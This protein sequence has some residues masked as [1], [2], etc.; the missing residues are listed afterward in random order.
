M[1]KA[2]I[3][4]LVVG[5]V[6]GLASCSQELT[7]LMG[8]MSTNI[9]GIEADTRDAAAATESVNN[10]TTISTNE[11]TGEVE[12]TINLEAAASIT[13][14]ISTIKKSSAKSEALKTQLSETVA[15]NE[16]EAVA[17][18]AAITA[19]ATEVATSLAPK[20][21]ENSLVAEL[22]SV[23]ENVSNSISDNPTKAELATVAI[24]S[25]IATTVN[26]VASAETITEEQ[27]DAYLEQG[28]AAYDTLVVVSDVAKLDV[29]GNIDVASLLR[30]YTRGVSR[31]EDDIPDDVKDKIVAVAQ[32]TFSKLLTML[33]TDKK[34]DVKK[35]NSFI[36]QATAI[37]ASI[38]LSA[39]KFTAENIDSILL[40]KGIDLGLTIDDLCL[41]LVCSLFVEVDKFG[42]LPTYQYGTTNEINYSTYK[43]KTSEL[44]TDELISANHWQNFF[45]EYLT[46]NYDSFSD[47]ANL[48][49][50]DLASYDSN[51]FKL[52]GLALDMNIDGELASWGQIGA[53]DA[54]AKIRDEIANDLGDVLKDI[55]KGDV[56]SLISNDVLAILKASAVLLVDC[57]YTGL[58]KLGGGDGSF[59]GLIERIK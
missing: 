23:L 58:M 25:Q 24:L 21:A 44:L 49:L 3:C 13:S 11:Q 53:E 40:N 51:L 14:S 37:K 7:N 30:D 1:K 56:N 31:S 41:Y 50:K 55:I 38:E 17:V 16:V 35:Y 43:D 29:I 4:L 15:S 8:S 45:G 39:S 18:K 26:N 59:S 34:F 32:Q 2:L 48:S 5:M 12:V 10:S 46:R 47:I 28:L 20:A 19:A 22:Q 27:K 54:D 6:I 33:T 36:L 57:D 9:Y 42:V 52:L